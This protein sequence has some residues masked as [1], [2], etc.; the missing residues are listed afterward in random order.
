MLPQDLQQAERRRAARLPG[1]ATWVSIT[2]NPQQE[3]LLS[4]QG[5]TGIVLL[6]VQP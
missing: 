4:N 2:G 1:I 3:L 5:Q 6:C